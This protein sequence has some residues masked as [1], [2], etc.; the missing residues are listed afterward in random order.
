[1]SAPRKTAPPTWTDGDKPLWRDGA[2]LSAG[3]KEELAA[4][5]DEQFGAGWYDGYDSGDV[6]WDLVA[7]WQDLL[8]W[9][10]G[11]SPRARWQPPTPELIETHKLGWTMDCAALLVT[12]DVDR[13]FAFPDQESAQ[14]VL[15]KLQEWAVWD[16]N[17]RNNFELLQQLVRG[18]S[19]AGSYLAAGVRELRRLGSLEGQ[20]ELAG[21]FLAAGVDPVALGSA[22]GDVVLRCATGGWRRS[23][24]PGHGHRQVLSDEVSLAVRE[25]LRVEELLIEHYPGRRGHQE[26]AVMVVALRHPT[27]GAV[28]QDV[29]D[30]LRSWIVHKTAAG[31]IIAY[32]Y[33][34]TIWMRT[35]RQSG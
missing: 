31:A 17:T 2:N 33:C 3:Q 34:A 8:S 30:R 4:W 26:K 25:V 21:I 9:E 19:L 5:A 28:P 24:K 12:G 1:V 22:A 27:L 16:A 15:A 6:P 35:A 14:L 7:E 18:S 11:S 10:R 32:K 20:S 13:R 29:E 23:G